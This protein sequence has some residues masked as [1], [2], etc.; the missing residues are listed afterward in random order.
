MGAVN[1]T[2]VME[3]LS[4]L[5][6]E[7]SVPSTGVE[8]RKRFI[9]RALDRVYRAYDWP[10]NKVT[11]TISMVAGI[12][13]LPSNV[14]QDSILDIRSVQA[15]VGDDYVYQQVP[16]GDLDDYPTGQYR[17]RLTGYEG[18]YVLQSS[19][20]SNDTLQ[21]RYETTSPIINASISTPF[22]SSMCLARGALVYYR[23]AEDPQADI[24]QEEAL[25]QQE[26]DE[27]IAQYNRGRPQPRAR[28]L[29]EA[30]GTYPGD[31]TDQGAFLNGAN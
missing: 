25:F 9:Q 5:L 15:G 21:I 31:I 27:V 12:A 28:T 4:F 7:S 29:H 3:D 14:Q 18:T 26:L 22:P 10:M 2:T 23:Q 20:T 11:A 30:Y 24:A 16:Y 17:Y 19:E 6:G 8:D 13:S 1:Q